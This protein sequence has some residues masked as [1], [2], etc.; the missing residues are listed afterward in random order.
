MTLRSTEVSMPKFEVSFH[1][2]TG[3]N[4]M[5]WQLRFFK[6]MLSGDVPQACN[7]PAGLGKTSVI[8]I[9]LIALASQR[10]YAQEDTTTKTATLSR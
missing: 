5:R 3:Y 7:L 1:A 8:P 6:R 2:L 9:W 4:P 10:R